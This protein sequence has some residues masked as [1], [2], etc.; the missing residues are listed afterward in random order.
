MEISEGVNEIIHG[1]LDAKMYIVLYGINKDDHE[2][3]GHPAGIA[4]L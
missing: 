1:D 4:G 2:G 3:Y